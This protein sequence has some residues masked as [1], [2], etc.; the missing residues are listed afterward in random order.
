M[1]YTVKRKLLNF[2]A[3]VGTNLS[4]FLCYSIVFLPITLPFGLITGTAHIVL[5]NVALQ[6]CTIVFLFICCGLLWEKSN[7]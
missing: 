5:L 1:G 2:L 3:R 4:L 6:F 7:D